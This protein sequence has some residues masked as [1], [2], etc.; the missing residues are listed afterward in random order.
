MERDLERDL[1]RDLERE[2]ADPD[3][4]PAADDLEPD[5]DLRSLAL[6]EV[7]A[8][9]SP[10]EDEDPIRLFLEGPAPVS[11]SPSLAILS[12]SLPPS[13]SESDELSMARETIFFFCL[14][15]KMEK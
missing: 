15:L 3:R 1:D 9:P 8:S 6:V 10:S 14:V 4:D 12:F 5:R 2:L 7:L 11:L 13:L